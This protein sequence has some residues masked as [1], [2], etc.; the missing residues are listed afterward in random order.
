MTASHGLYGALIGLALYQSLTFF[1]TFFLCYKSSWFKLH[2][3]IGKVDPAMAKKL[4]KYALMSIVS[5]ACIPTTQILIRNYLGS[6]LGWSSAGYWE[7]ITRLSS[8]YLMLITTTLSVYYLPKL[9]ELDDPL[10]IKTEIFNT[11]KVILPFSICCSIVIYLFRDLIIALIFTPSF[12]P[13]KELFA[14][15]LVGDTFKIT[16]WLLGYVYVAKGFT[17]LYVISEIIFSL[18]FYLLVV[19]LVNKF[20]L[21]AVVL[22][23]TLNYFFHF[24]F[25]LISLK[26]YRVL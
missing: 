26:V 3:F 23:Y 9:S 24:I 18:L 17:T 25:V 6:S 11:Y 4:L 7:A 8:A 10:K 5:A 14:W 16:S 12:I 2:Y 20:Q 15:Q 13:M 22:A 21:K 19:M 1:V